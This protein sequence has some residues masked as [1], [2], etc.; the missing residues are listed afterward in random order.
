M[1]DK[2]INTRTGGKEFLYASMI[3]DISSRIGNLVLE[4]YTLWISN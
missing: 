2:N 4:V 1:M 3:T